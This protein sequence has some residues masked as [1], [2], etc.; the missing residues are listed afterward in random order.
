MTFRL[1]D[2]DELPRHQTI[3]SFDVVASDS[4]HWSDGYYFTTG[5]PDGSVA[6][7]SGFRLHPN[8]DVVDAFTCVARA[9]RQHNMRFSRRL[10]PR[11]DELTCGAQSVEIVRPLRTLRTVAAPNPYGIAYDLVWEG[12]AAPYAEELVLGWANGRKAHERSNYDQCCTVDGWLELEGRRIEVRGWTGVRDHSWGLGQTGGPPSNAVAPPLERPE[13]FGVRMW[14]VMRLPSRCVFWQFHR[15][16]AGELTKF[17]GRI[18][19]PYG[20][21]HPPVA[22]TGVT[23]ELSFV[24]GHRRLVRGTVML[25]RADGGVD[26]FA[27][28]VISDPVY[29]QGGGYWRG[30]DDGGGRGVYRGE[31]HH[32]G[33]VWDVGSSP[34]RIGDPKGLVRERPDAWAETWGRCWNLDDP[35]ERG[36]GHLECV[37]SGPY[38]G[39]A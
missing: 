13:P 26:R 21:G 6:L 30:F 20:A 33:E 17:E 18:L 32:E 10:R 5:A 1:T 16:A 22:Y 11:I 27:V 38:P 28:E 25:E 9:G 2:L 37:V 29:L 7:F 35:A 3:A 24:P 14:V 31:H 4:P 8:T 39:F 23:E 34:T 36:D 19:W 12:V 15:S